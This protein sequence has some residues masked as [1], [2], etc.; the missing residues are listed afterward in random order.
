VVYSKFNI[1]FMYALALLIVVGD[2]QEEILHL[3]NA[4][5]A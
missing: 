1:E 4:M 3:Q 5:P 2:Y